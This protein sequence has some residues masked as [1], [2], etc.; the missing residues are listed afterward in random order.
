MSILFGPVVQQ[1]Y[2][3]PDVEAAIAHW[4]ARGIGPFFL[5]DITDFSGEYD[6]EPTYVIG[7]SFGVGF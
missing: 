7:V 1:G 2:V 6:G 3:V 4:T 5:M